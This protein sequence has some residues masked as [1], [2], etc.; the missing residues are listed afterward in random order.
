[1]EI[2]FCLSEAKDLEA[3]DIQTKNQPENFCLGLRPAEAGKLSGRFHP[4]FPILS[5]HSIYF[6]GLKSL[7]ALVILSEAK[8]LAV[9]LVAL[10]ITL[11]IH[12]VYLAK[13]YVNNNS[14]LLPRC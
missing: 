3:K 2:F 11:G 12:I 6:I 10:P 14:I 13:I 7:A 5:G 4:T 1:V 8:D 9:K